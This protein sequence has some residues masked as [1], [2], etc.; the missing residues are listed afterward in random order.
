M[1]LMCSLS[2]PT[3]SQNMASTRELNPVEKRGVELCLNSQSRSI[4]NA[5]Y[6]AVYAGFPNEVPSQKV[7]IRGSVCLLPNEG[8]IPENED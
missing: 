2:S 3:P 5:L 7:G 6:C 8:L 1:H 4:A